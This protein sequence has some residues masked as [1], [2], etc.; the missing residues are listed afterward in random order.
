[1][2]GLKIKQ[3]ELKG[4]MDKLKDMEDDLESSMQKKK[5]LEAE[6]TLCSQK[7]ERAESLIGG[8]GGEKTRWTEVAETLGQQYVCITGES[9][10]AISYMQCSLHSSGTL[11]L[12]CVWDKRGPC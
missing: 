3:D 5:Q 10:N 7:L 9:G 2:K 6:V 12:A 11:H 1:M 8:L 4:I